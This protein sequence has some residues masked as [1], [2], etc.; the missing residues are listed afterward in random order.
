KIVRCA[1]GALGAGG[2]Q[3]VLE[4]LRP[5]RSP[6][7]PRQSHEAELLVLIEIADD[8]LELGLR[9]VVGK[10]LEDGFGIMIRGSAVIPGRHLGGNFP[11]LH[12]LEASLRQMAL[13]DS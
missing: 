9:G 6:A 2:G 12:A 10:V 11:R 1:I 4:L 13:N 8:V 3:S 7:D 5:E